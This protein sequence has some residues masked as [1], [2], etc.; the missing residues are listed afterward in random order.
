MHIT[1]TDDDVQIALA[2]TAASRAID[3]RTN[4]QFGLVAAPEARYYTAR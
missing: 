4:R 3:R 1:D 2:V